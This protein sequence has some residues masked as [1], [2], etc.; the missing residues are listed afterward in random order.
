ML[1]VD[2]IAHRLDRLISLLEEMK[3]EAVNK[4]DPQEYQDISNA[5]TYLGTAYDLL[6]TNKN[7]KS[8]LI[9][10]LLIDDY[11]DVFDTE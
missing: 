4:S 3:E 7:I 5:I 2:L 11:P 9:T 10:E 1:P 8:R 6:I